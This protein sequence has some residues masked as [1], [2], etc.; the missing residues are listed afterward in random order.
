MHHAILSHTHHTEEAITHLAKIYPTAVREQEDGFKVLAYAEKNCSATLHASLMQVW[1]IYES[2]LLLSKAL[3]SE[4]NGMDLFF[5]PQQVPAALNREDIIS[6]KFKRGN[7]RER[8]VDDS[9]S[10]KSETDTDYVNTSSYNVPPQQDASILMQFADSLLMLYNNSKNE[11][12]SNANLEGGQDTSSGSE[13]SLSTPLLSRHVVESQVA[14]GSSEE[15]EGYDYEDD[16][17]D[18]NEVANA[19]ELL[20]NAKRQRIHS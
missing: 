14:T 8:E 19:T 17:E 9:C 4:E 6:K 7:K 16:I 15:D 11:K 1:R 10:S 12:L 18:D 5:V 20:V 3:E 13:S 2:S